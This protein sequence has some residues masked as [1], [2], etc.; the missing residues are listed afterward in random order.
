MRGS[1]CPLSCRRRRRRRLRRPLHLQQDGRAWFAHGRWGVVL[2]R[3]PKGDRGGCTV[4][5]AVHLTMFARSYEVEVLAVAGR[6]TWCD[7]L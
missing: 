6:T 3:C 4:E 2:L 1:D 7:K 5:E